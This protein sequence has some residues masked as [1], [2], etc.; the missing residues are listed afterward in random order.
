M[1]T[2]KR[3]S[4]PETVKVNELRNFLSD[5]FGL[6]FNNISHAK[7]RKALDRIVKPIHKGPQPKRGEPKVLTRN[8]FRQLISSP[9][10]LNF[11]LSKMQNKN[12]E[13]NKASQKELTNL[14]NAQKEQR[15]EYL[16][17]ATSYAS[18]LTNYLIVSDDDSGGY[19]EEEMKQSGLLDVRA[20]L[21]L[22][23]N[24]KI[25]DFITEFENKPDEYEEL[26]WFN[27]GSMEDAKKK[28]LILNRLVI[29]NQEP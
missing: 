17:L 24:Q 2:F 26:M 19:S 22:A 25:Q 12:L 7:N 18:L 14:L 21:L 5:T 23:T 16:N 29:D 28:A 20:K 9:K 8:E 6:K 3:D 15:D 1:I 10:F 11:V 4:L 13:D 27:N